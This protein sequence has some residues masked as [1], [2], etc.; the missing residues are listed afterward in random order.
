MPVASHS[1]RCEVGFTS[2]PADDLATVA[3]TDITQYLRLQDGVSL[4]RGRQDETQQVG[5]G[6]ASFTL[7]N[8]DKRFTPGNTS[9]AYYP[10]V[11]LRRP[12]RFSYAPAGYPVRT[13]AARNPSLEVDTTGWIGIGTSSITR[14]TTDAYVGSACLQS[15]L[16]N[17]ASATNN[18]A[19]CGASGHRSAITPS[20]PHTY[21]VYIKQLSGATANYRLRASYYAAISGG[22]LLQQTVGSTTS[23]ATGGGWTR[24]TFTHTSHASANFVAMNVECSSGAAGQVV[25]L[26]AVLIEQGSTVGDYFDGD[27]SGYTWTGVEHYSSSTTY[28]EP[29][30]TGYVDEWQE[31]WNA[32]VQPIVRVTASDL[33][34]RIAKH[35]YKALTSEELLYDE[36]VLF[37]P[38]NDA[39][40][41]TTAGN[42]A[43][44]TYATLAVT[45]GGTGGTIAFG[46]TSSLGADPS[47]SCAVFTRVDASNGKFLTQTYNPLPELDARAA[48]TL[49]SFIYL[50]LAIAG[51][52]RAVE[53]AQ[54]A[55]TNLLA[56]DLSTNVPVA[57]IE[58]GGSTVTVTSAGGA[59]NDGAWHHVAVVY[60]SA[61]LTLYVDGV[62][63]GSSAAALGSITRNI[64]TVGGASNATLLYNG[65]LS[66]VAVCNAALSSP[67][68]LAHAQTRNG[69]TGDTS[70]AR[71]NRLTR[72]AIGAWTENTSPYAP[73]ATMGAQPFAGQSASALL[74]GV[75]DAEVAPVYISAAGLPTWSARTQRT[76]S[77]A[78]VTIDASG[79]S[80]STGFTTSDAFVVNDVTL[81]RPGGATVNVKDSASV[82]AY[83]R[84]ELSASIYYDSDAQLA[85]AANFILNSRSQPQLRT[86]A[87]SVDLVT[88]DAP[89]PYTLLQQDIGNVLRIENLPRGSGSLV[90]VYVEGVNDYINHVSWR[91]TFNT[92]PL[93]VGGQAWLLDSTE[94][95]VLDSTTILSI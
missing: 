26:D 27:T 78:P 88:L 75:A 86:G 7:D 50:P 83:G 6:V 22:S 44:N 47:E 64:L 65:W 79:V 91:R 59:I 21:S 3:W 13:N 19:S 69:C 10:N 39:S 2:T 20:T 33:M 95:S 32:G 18:V 48:I 54:F 29:V 56:I 81:Q 12:V 42:Q 35:T 4:T 40:G 55:S 73:S 84:L 28:F 38:L 61:N 93:Q 9:G 74:Y 5:P 76:P 77:V 1:L 53:L 63:Q 52:M 72:L 24:L 90:D 46:Q 34:A 11:R 25:L 67:R 87:L 51:S 30:W 17:D 37:Y 31:G 43:G 41:S 57:R 80:S 68:L 71:L 45:Q 66:G 15:T 23:I 14:V 16:P 36:P 85:G 94:F 49:E 92:S 82:S 58:Q 60:D 8:A 70:L 89:T 62:S